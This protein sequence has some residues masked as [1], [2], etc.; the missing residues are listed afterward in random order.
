MKP[1]SLYFSI[2]RYLN[3]GFD[4]HKVYLR[5]P[6]R[7]SGLHIVQ[8]LSLMQILGFCKR[9]AVVKSFCFLKKKAVMEKVTN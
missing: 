7:A 8:G 5:T 2:F 9:D 6:M 1:L 4:D 3:S